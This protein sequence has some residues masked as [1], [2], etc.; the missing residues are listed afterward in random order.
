VPRLQTIP[1][2]EEYVCAPS[3]DVVSRSRTKVGRKRIPDFCKYLALFLVMSGV[4]RALFVVS[5]WGVV[6]LAF[7]FGAIWC[8]VRLTL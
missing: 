8:R 2:E 6:R 4:M 1:E 7:G 3:A 5:F